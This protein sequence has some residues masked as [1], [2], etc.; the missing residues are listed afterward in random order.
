MVLPWGSEQS[1]PGTRTT[2]LLSYCV[3]AR[4]DSQD[5]LDFQGYR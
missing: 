4:D 5:F 1:I 2:R 3:K